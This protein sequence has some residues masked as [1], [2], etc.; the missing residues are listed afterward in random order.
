MVKFQEAFEWMEKGY[1]AKAYDKT[2]WKINNNSWMCFNE[3]KGY[4]QQWFWS[5]GL[6]VLHIQGLWEL[7]PTTLPDDPKEAVKFFMN[8]IIQVVDLSE[9]ELGYINDRLKDLEIEL[10]DG[11]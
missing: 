3:K 2:R 6:S 11:K 1:I 9:Y 5:T 4:N 10:P 7:L 8:D